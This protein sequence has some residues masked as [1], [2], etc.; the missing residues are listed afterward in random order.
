MVCRAAV[1]GRR[2]RHVDCRTRSRRHAGP[3]V[4]L[5]TTVDEARPPGRLRR[6]TMLAGDALGTLVVILCVPFV[7]LALGLPI[8]LC[9]R[10]LLWM[11]GML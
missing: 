2:L 11:F 1:S 6:A 9:V 5:A 8:A 4:T 10:L 7:I 3:F